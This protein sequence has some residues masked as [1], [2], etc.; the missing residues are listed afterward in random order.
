MPDV[1]IGYTV[2][3]YHGSDQMLTTL[4]TGSSITQDKSVAKA[5]SHQPSLV[6]QFGRGRVR[7]DGQSPGYLYVVSEA[8]GP[9]DVR[10]H[11]HP[12]NL[13]RW[14][15]LTEREFTLELIERTVVTPAERLTDQ[16]IAEVRRK[17][18][19]RGEDSFLEWLA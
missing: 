15:W 6:L 17:Q 18:T 13:D 14:E 1:D 7:H 11:P 9:D 16:K 8:I 10:P 19:A 12:V 5:F 3:W 2:L 4:R